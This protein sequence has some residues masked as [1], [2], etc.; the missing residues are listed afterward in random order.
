[1][2]NLAN[3]IYVEGGL[4]AARPATPS[5]KVKGW[6]A[7]DTDTLSVWDGAAWHDV[8]GSGGITQL[9]GDATA[10]PGT[11]SQAVVVVKINGSPLGT[12]TGASVNDVLTWDGSQWVPATPAAGTVT[13][14]GSSDSSISVSNPTTTP[15]LVIATVDGG[16]A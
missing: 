12:T 4:A 3:L 7:T 6:Y 5:G 14:V 15:D 1:M 10:G 16:S 2:S 13:S 11:G 8:G 9:T